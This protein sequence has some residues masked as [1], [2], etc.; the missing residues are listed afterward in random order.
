MNDI[1]QSSQ[2]IIEE[3]KSQILEINGNRYILDNTLAKLYDVE[4]KMLKRAVKRNIERFPYDFM[5]ELTPNEILRCQNGTTS[6]GGTRYNSYAFTEEGVA[7]LSSVLHSPTAVQVNINIMRAFVEMRKMLS[8]SRLDLESVRQELQKQRE[9]IDNIM[10]TQNEVNTELSQ[11][12][13]LISQSLAELQANNNF[14]LEN[15]K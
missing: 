7:M 8:V 10:T 3:I 5:I 11:Q 6:W 15:L 13:Q 14:M 9:Y 1:S 12:L 4:T 2:I